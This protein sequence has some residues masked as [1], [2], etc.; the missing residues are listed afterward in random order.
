[1]LRA[2]LLHGLALV[3]LG[4]VAAAQER[5]PPVPPARDPGG[6][7]IAL[8]STGIDYTMPGIARRLARDGEGE[9]IG[10]DLEDNDRQPFDKSEGGTAPE[11]G[12]DGTT[13]ASFLID[14]GFTRLVPVRVKT[15]EPLSL[16]RALA[17]V[18]QTPAR[19][20]VVPMRSASREM[21]EPFRQASLRFKNLLVIVPAGGVEEAGYPTAFGLDT[22]LAVAPT[23]A[24]A[25]A[26][27]FGSRIQAIP[28]QLLAVAAAARSAAAYLER[29]PRLVASALKTRLLDAGGGIHWQARR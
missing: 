10:W 7:A 15:T 9:L 21:W 18:A 26:R 29:E 25:E 5:K 19:V 4:V 24:V 20:V 8:I 12:G 13:L 22:V 16:A 1:M 11:W 17:F 27:G 3:A 2:F 6:V 23:E 14:A 28:A